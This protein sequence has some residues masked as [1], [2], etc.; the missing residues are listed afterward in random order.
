MIS[1]LAELISVGKA[2]RDFPL[3]MLVRQT[4][5]CQYSWEWVCFFFFFETILVLVVACLIPLPQ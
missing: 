4:I 1:V 5:I 3:R 2:G